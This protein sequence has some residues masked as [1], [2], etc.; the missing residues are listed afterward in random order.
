LAP[1]LFRAEDL[2]QIALLLRFTAKMDD[3]R[4][5]NPQPQHVGQG[6]RL[7][8]RHLLPE[9]DLLHQAGSAPSVFFG[10]GDA[11][12][13][14]FI[15]PALPTLEIVKARLQRF[16]AALAPVFGDI[17]SEP[18]AQFIAK[19]D[20]FRAEI[21]VHKISGTCTRSGGWITI[22]KMNDDS[23]CVTQCTRCCASP[24]DERLPKGRDSCPT[25]RKPRV[26]GTPASEPRTE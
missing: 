18:G 20:F 11:R 12:P 8:Q 14:A 3:G 6:R 25:T 9:D 21:Q 13:A 10:P 1:D 15:E 26:V 24:G 22:G 5:D 2:G 7:S 17:G 16:F 19:S 23:F 4:P